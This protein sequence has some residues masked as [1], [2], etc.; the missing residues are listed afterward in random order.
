MAVGALIFLQIAV[1]ITALFAAYGFRDFLVDGWREG[2]LRGIFASPYARLSG[3]LVALILHFSVADLRVLFALPAFM[4]AMRAL[5]GVEIAA[6]LA[7]E[8]SAFLILLGL[9]VRRGARV[10][11]RYCGLLLGLLAAAAVIVGLI[12]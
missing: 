10:Q 9:V 5:S 4:A 6:V 1:A 3:L 7:I 8:G 11:E 2:G 12:L